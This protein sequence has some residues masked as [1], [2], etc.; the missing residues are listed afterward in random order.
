MIVG[1]NK[2]A[3]PVPFRP[4]SMS[5]I[6]TRVQHTCACPPPQRSSARARRLVLVAFV[7]S[8]LRRF[9]ALRSIL[10]CTSKSHE[11]LTA[12]YQHCR[13]HSQCHPSSIVWDP[14]SFRRLCG[15]AGNLHVHLIACI[16][17]GHL[18]PS[19]RTKQRGH[20]W[21]EGLPT[22]A[23]ATVKVS[24]ASTESLCSSTAHHRRDTT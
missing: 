11:Y 9:V 8:S 16:D 23:H 24:N 7:A 4:L 14:Q 10:P 3:S 18:Q 20:E 6:S 13:V 5:V 22:V 17:V 1:R 15:C 2:I 12:A 21:R 19:Y